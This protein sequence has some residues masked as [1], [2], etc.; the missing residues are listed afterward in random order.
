MSDQTAQTRLADVPEIKL[1]GELTRRE[2]AEIALIG[3]E[4]EMTVEGPAWVVVNHAIEVVSDET[5]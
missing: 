5:E 1:F 4:H 3:P 2:G